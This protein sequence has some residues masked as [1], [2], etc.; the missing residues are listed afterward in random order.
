MGLWTLGGC[1]CRRRGVDGRCPALSAGLI[2][3]QH[4]EER[5]YARFLAML[6]AMLKINFRQRTFSKQSMVCISEALHNNDINS[7]IANTDVVRLLHMCHQIVF[8]IVL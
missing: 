3:H 1:V 7:F 6:L 8:C 5:A 4:L 2:A